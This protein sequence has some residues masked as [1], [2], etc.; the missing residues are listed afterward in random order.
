MLEFNSNLSEEMKN[1]L[2]FFFP[3]L[4]NFAILDSL[5]IPSNPI[6]K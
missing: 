6:S 1:Y 4:A 3:E 5:L 2:S